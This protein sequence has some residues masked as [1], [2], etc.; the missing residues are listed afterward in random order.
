V[1][2]GA[3]WTSWLDAQAGP[4]PIKVAK[5]IAD[6][7][8]PRAGSPTLES[9]ILKPHRVSHPFHDQLPLSRFGRKRGRN[10]SAEG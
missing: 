7:M 10:G 8:V 1:K 6:A 3:L 9:F 4:M 5:A 2:A